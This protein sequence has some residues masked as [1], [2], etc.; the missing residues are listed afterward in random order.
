MKHWI[1]FKHLRTAEKLSGSD[2]QHIVKSYF[3]HLIVALREALAQFIMCIGSIVHGLFPFLIDFKLLDAVVNQ[4]IRLHKFLPQHP[5][6]EK[7][8]RELNNE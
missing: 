1:N 2:R 6:W 5:A 3:V 4:A 8:K 7:L